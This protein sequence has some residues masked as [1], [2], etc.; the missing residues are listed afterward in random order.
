MLPWLAFAAIS[1]IWGSTWLVH[2]YALADFTPLGLATTRFALAGVLCLAIGLYRGE[3]GCERRELPKLLLSG[4]ILLG[5]ANVLTAW[6]LTWIPS[7]VGAVLQAPI[8]VWM[9]LLTLR[10]EPLGK[11]GL[12]ATVLG[13]GGVALV[14]WPEERVD[15]ALLPALVCVGSGLM[16][17]WAALYQRRHVSSGGMF[18]NTGLQM[19][20]S[21]MVGALLLPFFGGVTVDGSISREAW[22][23]LAYLTLFGSLIAFSAFL[24]LTRVWHPARAGSFSY[25]NPL[26][27][28][29]LGVTLNNEPVTVK[30]VIGMGVILCSVALLQWVAVRRARD[31]APA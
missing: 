23:A 29:L 11:S 2:V 15:L 18:I 25:L 6:T 17:S 8:P 10:R 13:L 7:G 27:A 1:L 21:A 31:S 5:L 12:A 14:M 16:W 20:A 30:L 26:V 9:A 19:M 24:Y 3:Q 28:M 4:L 22:A